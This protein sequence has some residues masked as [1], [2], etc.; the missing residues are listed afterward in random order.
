MAW[1][2]P[3]VHLNA[4]LKGTTTGSRQ[5]F[6]DM[7]KFVERKGIRLVISR[8][9]PGLN[10]LREIDSLFDDMEVGRQMGK[11]IIEIEGQSSPRI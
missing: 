11:L 6:C 2:I 5:E 4:E 1:I 7:M 3:A 9:Y 8:T 10:N